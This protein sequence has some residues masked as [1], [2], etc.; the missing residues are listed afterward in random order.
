MSN[1]CRF[2]FT[3]C[4]W[5]KTYT[6]WF[7]QVGLPSHLAPGNLGL[8]GQSHT[9]QGEYHIFTTTND[10]AVIKMCPAFRQLANMVQPYIHPIDNLIARYEAEAISKYDVMSLCH[11]HSVQRAAQIGAG[12]VVLAP[13]LVLADGGMQTL[14]DLASSGKKLVLTGSLRVIGESF[15][16]EIHPCADK[17]HDVSL[18][19]HARELVELVFKHWHPFNQTY[20][21]NSEFFNRRWP[22]FL[23]WSVPNEGLV[24]RGIHLHPLL[25]FPTTGQQYRWSK[26]LGIDGLD[27]MIRVCPDQDDLH[28]IGDSDHVYYVNLDPQWNDALPRH[29]ASA[30]DIARWVIRQTCDHHRWSMTQ[31]IRHHMGA[32][33]SAWLSVEKESESAIHTILKYVEVFEQ[34][35]DLLQELEGRFAEQEGKIRELIGKCAFLVQDGARLRNLLG[36]EYY[37]AGRLPEAKTF[38]ET[39]LR[40]DPSCVD[41]QENLSVLDQSS[42]SMASTPPSLSHH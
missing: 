23:F 15:I 1:P 17:G 40:M 7:M 5:G 16:R 32:C 35:A 42:K 9:L 28:V 3:S 10:A 34:H 27:Y 2:V 12:L 25:S 11:A 31:P 38:W 39:A 20:L 14:L 29:K 21:W 22:A 4:V 6:Q 36:V 13:D 26:D 18:P 37:K 30:L 8:F 24:Q 41:A 19:L 33:S